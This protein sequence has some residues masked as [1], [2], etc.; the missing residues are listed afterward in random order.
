MGRNKVMKSSSLDYTLLN[1]T[2][3]SNNETAKRNLTQ[4][5][6]C[7]QSATSN[8]TLMLKM[9]TFNNPQHKLN[10][11][12]CCDTV[13]VSCGRD[14]CDNYFKKICLTAPSGT[15]CGIGNTATQLIQDNA[16]SITFGS[17]IGG[18]SNPIEYTFTK[19]EVR[20]F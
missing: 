14:H 9:K 2:S 20:S 3:A 8:G 16:D 17:K 15:S 11:G 1:G 10:D 5:V 12:S 4:A 6:L 19:W 13:Y 18:V 7:L